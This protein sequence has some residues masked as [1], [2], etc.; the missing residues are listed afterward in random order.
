MSVSGE[1]SFRF[2]PSS[3]YL[4]NNNIGVNFR[5]FENGRARPR[6]AKKRDEK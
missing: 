3:L 6:G 5:T 4:E 1:F 2:S